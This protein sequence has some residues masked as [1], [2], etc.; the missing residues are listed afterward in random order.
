MK[1]IILTIVGI[2]L[3]IIG[4]ASFI[5]P[6]FTRLINLPGETSLKSMVSI[7]MGIVFILLGFIL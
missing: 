5:N 3:L 4:L 1:T 7:I 6:N 2:L